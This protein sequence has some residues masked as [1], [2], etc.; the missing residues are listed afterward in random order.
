MKN[1]NYSVIINT[2]SKNFTY[3][4]ND[5]REA[6]RIVFECDDENANVG[7]C[8]GHTG[9]VLYHDGEKPWCTDEMTLMML[10]F[11]VEQASAEEEENENK[12][13][14]VAAK[15]SVVAVRYD[16]ITELID[17]DNLVLAMLK[18]FIAQGKATIL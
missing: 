14:K 15:D 17:D 8:N 12:S 11:M 5:V 6:I 10:G 18:D 4:T 3:E 1:F 7:I 2:E 13:V 9:E 16:A